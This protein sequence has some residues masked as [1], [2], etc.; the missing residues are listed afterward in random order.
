MSRAPSPT[1]ILAHF[2]FGPSPQHS[3][4]LPPLHAPTTLSHHPPPS[5]FSS[6]TSIP[7]SS[8]NSSLNSLKRKL[9]LRVVPSET[10]ACYPRRFDGRAFFFP[11]ASFFSYSTSRPEALTCPS[12]FAPSAP[13][14]TPAPT[15]AP[16]PSPAPA[17]RYLTKRGIHS[18]EHCTTCTLPAHHAPTDP[19]P[20]TLHNTIAAPPLPPAH[21][22]SFTAPAVHNIA[23]NRDQ[24][25]KISAS[26]L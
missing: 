2:P 11:W 26:H 12:P 13:A 7:S 25:N 18:P 3:A 9:R 10:P 20:R 14:P 15:P 16:S 5:P 1:T 17:P 6:S 19:P 22:L 24:L 4:Q 8:R 21:P 23:N